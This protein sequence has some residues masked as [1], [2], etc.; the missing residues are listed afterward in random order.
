ML[1]YDQVS[2]DLN[3]GQLV[4]HGPGTHYKVYVS[5]GLEIQQAIYKQKT[6]IN[7]N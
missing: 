6:E 4:I 1:S 5:N 7:K 3:G 2:V